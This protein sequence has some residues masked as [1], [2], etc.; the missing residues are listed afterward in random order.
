MTMSSIHTNRS[1]TQGGQAQDRALQFLIDETGTGPLSV[2]R[3]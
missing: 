3:A 1:A 2:A